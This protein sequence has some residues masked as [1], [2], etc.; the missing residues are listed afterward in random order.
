MIEDERMKAGI[1][2]DISKDI[3]DSFYERCRKNDQQPDDVITVLMLA[4]I[5]QAVQDGVTDFSAE[6][7]LESGCGNVDGYTRDDVLKDLDAPDL[8]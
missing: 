8:I 2:F 1:T 6:Y 3:I 7:I 4:Y 5:D